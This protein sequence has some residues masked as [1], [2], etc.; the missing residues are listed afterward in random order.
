MTTCLTPSVSEFVQATCSG[1]VN[2]MISVDVDGGGDNFVEIAK[3]AFVMGVDSA[4]SLEETG[5]L[6]AV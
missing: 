5:N 1:W 3:L 6:I 2:T 4:E